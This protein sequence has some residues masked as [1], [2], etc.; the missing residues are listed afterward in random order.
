MGRLSDLHLDNHPPF[1][2]V[3][4]VMPIAP[5]TLLLLFD[6]GEYKLVSLDDLI[7]QDG[8]LFLPLRRWDFFRL[9]Q[10]DQDG[11]T[12]VWPNG[13]DLDPAMLYAAGTPVS[14]DATGL[15]PLATTDSSSVR[16]Q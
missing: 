9:V 12:V 2:A 13:L 14:L 16:M 3:A 6:T 4:G 15:Q 5:C 10:R 8:P 1:H 7:E 11:V